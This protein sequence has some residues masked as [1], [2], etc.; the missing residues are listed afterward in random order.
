MTSAKTQKWISLISEV[1]ADEAE[2]TVLG[3]EIN[4]VL[5]F[6]SL[7]NYEIVHKKKNFQH[8]KTCFLVDILKIHEKQ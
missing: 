8:L 2:L 5:Q 4:I 7:K 1:D 6:V 3:S